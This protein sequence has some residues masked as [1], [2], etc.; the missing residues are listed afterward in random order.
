MPKRKKSNLWLKKP[1][2]RHFPRFVTPKKGIKILTPKK[3]AAFST[4]TKAGRV[5]KRLLTPESLPRAIRKKLHIHESPKNKF[6]TVLNENVIFDEFEET[7]TEEYKEYIDIAS[8]KVVMKK[9]SEA[10]LLYY[11]VLFF[12][13]VK[14]GKYS[15]SNIAMLLWL[16][17]VRWFSL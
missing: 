17:T 13:L 15:L 16:E 3:T 11:F 5:F 7:I 10:G 1:K 9:L 8:D 12:Q 6:E 2:R 4:P 14:A